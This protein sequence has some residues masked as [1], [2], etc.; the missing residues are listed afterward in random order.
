MLMMLAGKSRTPHHLDKVLVLRCLVPAAAHHTSA[1]ASSSSDITIHQ[2]P[3]IRA[4][5]AS[6]HWRQL[7]RRCLEMRRYSGYISAAGCKITPDCGDCGGSVFTQD[8]RTLRTSVQRRLLT[9]H[10]PALLWIIS[11]LFY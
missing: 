2:E 7:E 8:S 11:P 10:T 4:E 9:T 3:S 1:A 6:T 5:V